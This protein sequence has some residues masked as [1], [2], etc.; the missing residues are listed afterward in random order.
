MPYILKYPL[1]QGGGARKVLKTNFLMYI[2][3]LWL[4]VLAVRFAILEIPMIY[5]MC[6]FH[7]FGLT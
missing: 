6:D 3:T 1:E 4:L 7:D 5:T 2:H